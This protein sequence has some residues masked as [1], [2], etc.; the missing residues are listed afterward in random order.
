[1]TYIVQLQLDPLTNGT[2]EII[3]AKRLPTTDYGVLQ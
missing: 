1:M 3:E 2:S